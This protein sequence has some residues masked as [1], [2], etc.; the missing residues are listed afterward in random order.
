MLTGMVDFDLQG[1][2]HQGL[3]YLCLP[4]G[5]HSWEPQ[6]HTDFTIQSFEKV[7]HEADQIEVLLIGTGIT[8]VPLNNKVRSK[9]RELKIIADSMSTGAAV[10]TFNVL[11]S[12]N[13]AVAT[14]L[15]AVA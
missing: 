10:R 3:N 5:I 7:F 14:A 12:E 9:F 15:I 8:L 4:S 11:L 2:S 6:T 1:M 13:R